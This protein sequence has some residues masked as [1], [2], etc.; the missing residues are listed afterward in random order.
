MTKFH[1]ELQ[2]PI[3]WALLHGNRFQR[4]EAELVLQSRANDLWYQR[5][6]SLDG[7]SEGFWDKDGLPL[8][9]WVISQ[10]VHNCLV[11]AIADMTA[12]GETDEVESVNEVLRLLSKPIYQGGNSKENLVTRCFWKRVSPVEGERKAGCL[13]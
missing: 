11:R 13:K 9:R 4:V 8:D 5:S 1:S 6:L 10:R 7:F 12:R 3:V 2:E